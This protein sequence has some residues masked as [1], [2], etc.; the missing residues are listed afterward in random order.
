MNH[1]SND[2]ECKGFIHSF[3]HDLP[4]HPSSNWTLTNEYEI[5]YNIMTTSNKLV[6]GHYYITHP[7]DG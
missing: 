2:D 5:M 1:K 7:I 3:I 4:P 6:S